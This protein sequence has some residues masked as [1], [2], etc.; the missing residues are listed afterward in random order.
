MLGTCRTFPFA[1]FNLISDLS[2]N[3]PRGV[4]P[5]L[6]A[7]L[8]WKFDDRKSRTRIIFDAVILIHR[9]TLIAKHVNARERKRRFIAIIKAV[10]HRHRFITRGTRSIDSVGNRPLSRAYLACNR[11]RSSDELESR[12]KGR[13]DDG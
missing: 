9:V 12:G 8:A 4:I 2:I 3:L 6:S 7:S 5:P 11:D 1:L 13:M 10:M